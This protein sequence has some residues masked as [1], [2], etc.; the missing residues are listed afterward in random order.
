MF[1]D[2]VAFF[3]DVQT[4]EAVMLAIAG[5]IWLLL[6]L[7]SIFFGLRL[8]FRRVEGSGAASVPL[9]VIVV[10]RNEEEN[11][12][13][14]LP[15]WLSMGYP[16]YEVLVVDDFSEDNSQT[17]V[18]L[19]RLKE[20]KLRMTGLNQETRYSSKLARN[21]GLKAAAH[22]RV[23]FIQPDSLTPDNHWLPGIATAF[24]GQKEVVVGYTR[25]SAARG[26]YHHLFRV[27][28]FLQQTESMAF[29]INGLPFVA[30]EENIAFD[31]KAYFS[32]SGFAG[33]IGEEYL[34]MELVFN[35]IISRKNSTV[36]LAGNLSVERDMAA[37]K[38]DFREL[39]YKS[40]VLNGYLT[41]GIRALRWSVN[42][43]KV[44]FL[45]FLVVCFVLFKPLWPLLLAMFVLL[46]VIRGVYMK[47]L[48][49]RLNESGFF[50]TS[51]LYGWLIPYIRIFTNWH[52]RYKR[53]NP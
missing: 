34:N 19:L 33:K 5:A 12:R 30:M 35:Q 46:A 9:S 49:N 17:I 15:G 47:R 23:V 20:P 16:D 27:E 10:E 37:R 53:R 32:I 8:A 13:E 1:N 11:L 42:W 22:D 7:H 6:L 4:F 39:Y 21:L 18:G 45:P 3:R 48:F 41:F 28:S 50:V 38:Q 51:L 14:K 52:F 25:F 31:R 2:L 36:L 44:I 40:F 24:S 43:L 26:F 29:C